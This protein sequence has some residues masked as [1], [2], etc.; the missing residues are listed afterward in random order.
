M[1][2]VQSLRNSPDKNVDVQNLAENI[3]NEIYSYRVTNTT[4]LS[5]PVATISF[6]GIRLQI[7]PIFP[8]YSFPPTSPH[9]WRHFR[10]TVGVDPTGDRSYPP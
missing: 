8:P 6:L 1:P 9:Q 4:K 5:R 3:V 2:S 7:P 10:K